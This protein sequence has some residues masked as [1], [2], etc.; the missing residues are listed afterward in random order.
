MENKDYFEKL[1]QKAEE[2]GSVL[3]TKE[4]LEKLEIERR[5]YHILLDNTSD[6]VFEYDC[7]SDIMYTYGSFFDG[8]QTENQCYS[9]VGFRTRVLSGELV[10]IEDI[11]RL[12]CFLEGQGEHY[13]ECRFQVKGQDVVSYIWVRLEGRKTVGAGG[14]EH[15]IGCF[16]DIHEQ[17]L[18]ELNAMEDFYRNHLTGFYQKVYA[19]RIIDQRINSLPLDVV[20]SFY[21]LELHNYEDLAE[22]EGQVFAD[23]LVAE[24]A[25]LL[26]GK[27]DSEYVMAYLSDGV[28][29]IFCNH[30]EQDG[31]DMEA[32]CEA[33][34]KIYV[35]EQECLRPKLARVTTENF[36]SFYELIFQARVLLELSK[37]MP[38]ERNVFRYED[39]S[40]DVEEF[41]VAF[42]EFDFPEYKEPSDRKLELSK[43]F[44]SF[45]LTLLEGVRNFKHG[46]NLLL[47]ILTER[48]KLSGIHILEGNLEFLAVARVYS[49]VRNGR[50]RES[51]EGVVYAE[52]EELEDFYSLMEQKN[53]FV[54][55]N[56]GKTYLPERGRKLLEC[57]ANDAQYWELAYRNGGIRG[58]IIFER[59]NDV[60]MESE[61]QFFQEISKV[62][63]AYIERNK[64]LA[65]NHSKTE[66]LRNLSH[67]IR[68]PVNSILGMTM[69]AKNE[70]SNPAQVAD[71]LEKIDASVKY[72]CAVANDIV[73]MT[74]LEQG[75]LSVHKRVFD[76]NE[77]LKQLETMFCVQAKE[78]AVSFCVE[79]RVQNPKMIGDSV[80]ISQ[81]LVNL[82]ENALKYT[83]EG[84]KVL[85]SV[86][87]EE[88]N[89]EYGL[90]FTVE[91]TGIG[92]S[93][94]KLSRIRE[95][96]EEH[97]QD[98]IENRR[99]DGLGLLVCN[100]ILQ[101]M[102]S[103]LKLQSTEG[104]GSRFSFYL[105]LPLAES[106]RKDR[107][108]EESCYDFSNRRVLLVEDNEL[109]MEIEKY[110]LEKVGFTVE[111][112][113]NG[114]VA[115]EMYARQDAGYYDVIL[116]DIRMPEMDGL[117][118]TRFIRKMG[119]KDS[120]TI[121]II[122]MTA[123]AFDE[124]E[125]RSL[126]SGM[127][128]HLSKPMDIKLMMQVL[129]IL[130][131]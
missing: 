60:W 106:G 2:T 77:L 14:K 57:F 103:R 88:Q 82:I 16:R 35:S 125:K 100:R 117:T 5:H 120:Q 24:T 33:V 89:G 74:Q 62:I 52:R 19:E 98:N 94:E 61:K 44:I 121:P 29:V 102:G 25:M 110:V 47:A 78:N 28:F 18:I 41:E 43:D 97:F 38:E 34:K 51:Q 59:E 54:Y 37:D 42:P 73:D 107:M 85:L 58:I 69:I 45:S 79:N 87:Q 20:S 108:Q 129:E 71:C 114:K 111:P 83:P 22:R 40:G 26:D 112:A 4:E 56:K 53:S 66:L 39:Y 67:E 3:I 105:Y 90:R 131:S 128:G 48:M 7:S 68:T 95:E 113:E 31:I 1:L 75:S 49:Y 11:H 55:S 12:A 70:I 23:T 65:A 123:N 27:E 80:R 36:R 10:H 6:T 76:M 9:Y 116:M 127:D 93:K 21:L 122:G 101:F 126:E 8:K 46:M 63:S 64:E 17:K 91:D 32:V 99:K 119:R 84:G 50:Q 30:A 15:V 115:V 104:I 130:I 81:I 92:F 109:N 72:L 124:D 86:V 13:V 96:F 118:A